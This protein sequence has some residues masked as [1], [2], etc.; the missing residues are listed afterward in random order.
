MLTL[1]V[2]VLPVVFIAA[3]PFALFSSTASL[4]AFCY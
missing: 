4:S 2:I 3:S 1:F